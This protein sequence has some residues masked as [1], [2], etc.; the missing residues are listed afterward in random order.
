VTKAKPKKE[1]G[2]EVPKSRGLRRKTRSGL[3]NLT[4]FG[5]QV[6]IIFFFFFFVSFVSAFS[7]PFLRA[8][9]DS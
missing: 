2:A 3:G 9:S 5:C 7:S 1:E 6:F 8:R 4:H